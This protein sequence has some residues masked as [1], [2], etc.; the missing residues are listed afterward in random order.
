MSATFQLGKFYAVPSVRVNTWNGFS[1]WL[2]VIGPKHEDHGPVNFPWPHFHIDWRFASTYAFKCASEWRN[3]G[4]SF[5]YGSVLQCPDSY[6]RIVI[7]EGPTLK[8]MKCKRELPKYPDDKAVRWIARLE[9]EF[10][11][12]K[13][14]NGKCPHRGIPVE[15]MIRD[16]DVLTCPGHGLRWNAITGELMPRS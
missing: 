15:S 13:L 11:C 4:P 16:G 10:A 8:R 1:G 7:E 14:V 12:T 5:A 2:P 3:Q 9:Q 6:G